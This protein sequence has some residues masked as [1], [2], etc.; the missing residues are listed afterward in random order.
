MVQ[1]FYRHI[2]S[3]RIK[4]LT[5]AKIGSWVNAIAP[6]ETELREL[7]E[8]YGLDHGL[9]MDG[10]DL[11]ESPRVESE[12]GSTYIY[13][14]FCYSE[15]GRITT[16]P[17]LVVHSRQHLITISPKAFA[18]LSRLTDGRV[19]LVTTQKT[20]LMLQI[21]DEVRASYEK[22]LNAIS[23]TIYQI[24]SQL[25]KEQISNQDFVEFIDIEET[26][27]DFLSGLVPTAATLRSLL[28]GRYFKLYEEDEDLIEDL[29]L[30]ISELIDLSKSRLSTITNIRESY[31]TIMANNLNRIFK[32][33]TSI[34]ILMTI[35]TIITSIYS[36]NVATPFMHNR[37]AFWI[38]SAFILTAVAVVA[39]LFRRNKWF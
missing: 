36:M 28:S 33:L 16:A 35:P 12:D 24:R 18:G 5:S 17:L 14:R 13:T 7:A 21:L 39:W 25:R 26:L 31:S 23:K 32:L 19:P 11:H 22:N 1:I 8:T 38:I 29:T 15:N 34:T 20:K 6:S 3:E 27:G 9:L 2:R 37:M 30:G 4:T 10:T